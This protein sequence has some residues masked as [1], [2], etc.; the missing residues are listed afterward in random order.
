[1][2][3]QIFCIFASKSKMMKVSHI[4]V[5]K[6]RKNEY[7]W[8]AVAANKKVVADSAEGYKNI[9]GLLTGMRATLFCFVNE[10]L[11]EK[12]FPQLLLELEDKDVKKIAKALP[13]S[14]ITKLKNLTRRNSNGRNT[15]A[16][17][18]MPFI[19]DHGC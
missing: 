16:K 14:R 10:S 9:R 19:P 18:E 3:L 2:Y 8:Q 17:V 13:Q 12:F 15:I 4:K 5:Y 11:E 6:D 1:M 7:R